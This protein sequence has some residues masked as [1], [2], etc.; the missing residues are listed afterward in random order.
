MG[1]TSSSTVVAVWTSPGNFGATRDI[2]CSGLALD[3]VYR[4]VVISDDVIEMEPPDRVVEVELLL[5]AVRN[6]RRRADQQQIVRH[7]L[8]CNAPLADAVP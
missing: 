2:R 8:G 1:T 3:Q 4:V 5:E 6:V 7:S